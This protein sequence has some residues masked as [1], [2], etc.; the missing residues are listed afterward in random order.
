MINRLYIKNYAIIEEQEIAF[1]RNLTIITGETG[2]GKSILLGALGLIMGKRADSKVL[3]NRDTKCVV[4]AWFQVS[5]YDTKSF[6][7]EHDID[8][9]DEVIIRRELTPSGKSRAFINDTPV[10]LAV[11]K[12][13]SSA[14][15]DVHQQFDTLD[16][17]Q[18][19]F[20]MRTIDALAGNKE[21]LVRYQS[22]FKVY[23]KERKQLEELIQQNTYAEKEFDFLEFQLNEFLEADLEDGEQDNL[24]NEQKTLSNAENIK[25]ILGKAYLEIAESEFAIVGQLGNLSHSMGDLKDINPKIKAACE[26]LESI[27][28]ELEDLSSEFQ[29]I[30]ESTEYDEER[31]SEVTQRL[32]LIYKLLNKHHVQSIAQLIAIQNKLQEKINNYADLSSTIEKLEARINEMEV[33]LYEL[34]GQLSGRRKAQVESFE[35]SVHSLLTQLSM[36]HAQLKVD[37]QSLEDL[38]PTGTDQINFLFAANKG[39]RLELLKN[40]A[41]GGELSR[42]T[43]CVKSLVA[44]AIPLPTLVFD[45]IDSGLSGDVAM[46]MGN[47]LSEL[48]DQHQVITITHTPQIAAKAD[49]HYFVYKNVSGDRTLTSVKQLDREER[50]TEIATMLSGNP[51]SQSAVQNAQDLLSR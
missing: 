11:L 17:H 51:P 43:L 34:A 50:I 10:T 6:F 19:S 1:S 48:S 15:V 5:E 29:N 42:L 13:L 38:T 35:Q 22:Q 31:I 45:E 8:Y 37:I 28:V 41:S 25:S 20:Q 32:D 26:R 9:D 4:E 7:D 46:K 24:E 44:S 27:I 39:S 21:L 23:R 3:Y 49:K 30:A 2:A 18:V 14:L 12:T 47:I 33:A 40:V 36:E 16:I